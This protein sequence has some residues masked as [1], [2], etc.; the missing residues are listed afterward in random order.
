VAG[1]ATPT[2]SAGHAGATASSQLTFHLHN[3]GRSISKCVLVT[4]NLQT[5]ANVADPSI[6][7]SGWTLA[8]ATYPTVGTWCK[9][10]LTVTWDASDTT[11]FNYAYMVTGT[12]LNYD[13][14]N[15]PSIA[16]WGLDLR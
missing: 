2:G 15:S 8:S 14:D 5:C 12:D 6:T 10:T 11:F 4:V 1:C 3:A 7:G 9:I 13:G 16:I